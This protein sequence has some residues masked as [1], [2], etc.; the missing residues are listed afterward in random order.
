MTRDSRCP[1]EGRFDSRALAH[2]TLLKYDYRLP[3]RKVSRALKREFGLEITP[4]T[5]LD[6][7]RRVSHAPKDEYGDIKKRIRESDVVYVDETSIR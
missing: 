2:I 7:N 1:V 4:A 3:H 6:V 5:V